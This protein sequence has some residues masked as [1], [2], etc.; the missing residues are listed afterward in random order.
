MGRL[1]RQAMS[2]A[3]KDT[4]KN[5]SSSKQKDDDTSFLSQTKQFLQNFVKSPNQAVIDL[6]LSLI[7]KAGAPTNAINYLRDL[8]VS[9]PYRTSSA[10]RAG[11]NTLTGDG[12]FLDNY[13]QAL[14]NPSLYEIQ[15]TIRPLPVTN[16]N[17]SKDELEVLRK[18]SKNGSH[19][20]TNADI[21]RTSGKYGNAGGLSGMFTPDKVAQL[22]IG[23][24]SG[25]NGK[26]T[27]L[28]DVNTV[29]NQAKKD[30]VMYIEKAKANPG[31]NYETLRA[32][33]PVL[34]MI[35][36]MPDEYKIRT[37]L[38]FTQNK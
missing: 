29:S 3:Q 16:S 23:Q 37:D 21:I 34:N 6:G 2:A 26:V 25:G 20:I 30:N 4:K 32:L 33:M 18:Q 10:I 11:W 31:A 8:N 15:R 17:F 38:N 9:L 35:D 24:S 5:Q 19:G 28:F 7:D 36:I 27:D 22:S 12:N 1:T 13:N 14:A